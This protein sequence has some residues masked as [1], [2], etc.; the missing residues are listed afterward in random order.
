MDPSP[1]TLCPPPLPRGET[2]GK[3]S[4]GQEGEGSRPPAIRGRSSPGVLTGG[5]PTEGRAR[6]AALAP[7]GIWVPARPTRIRGAPPTPGRRPQ[8]RAGPR[9]V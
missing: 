5:Q 1:S 9:P 8:M 4:K 2:L 3:G 6:G 7:A